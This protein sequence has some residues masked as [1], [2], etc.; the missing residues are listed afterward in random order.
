MDERRFS[1][2]YTA[3]IRLSAEDTIDR[4]ATRACIYQ[5]SQRDTTGHSQRQSYEGRDLA[6]HQSRE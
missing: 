3:D 5:A 6:N 4:L 1:A 2:G